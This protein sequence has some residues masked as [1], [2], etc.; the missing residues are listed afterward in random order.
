MQ[1]DSQSVGNGVISTFARAFAP[2]KCKT[3]V[4]HLR[5]TWTF[6]QDLS[7]AVSRFSMRPVARNHLGYFYD[8]FVSNTITIIDR[9]EKKVF[10]DP[11]MDCNRI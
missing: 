2:K 11:I 6:L 7:R 5:M 9:I 3:A 8:S 10:S 1:S 4:S